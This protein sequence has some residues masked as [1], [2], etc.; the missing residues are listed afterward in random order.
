M[1]SQKRQGHITTPCPTA[2][3]RHDP[4][5]FA[6]CSRVLLSVCVSVGKFEDQTFFFAGLLVKRPSA[7]GPCDVKPN[8]RNS[9]ANSRHEQ[10]N[11][12]S[13]INVS[14]P[15]T[16]YVRHNQCSSGFFSYVQKKSR[17][18]PSMKVSGAVVAVYRS[19]W[20]HYYLVK[21]NVVLSNTIWAEI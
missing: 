14:T 10:R 5:M 17:V 3:E 19:I 4:R 20:D 18:F 12:C 6:L 13:I 1:L 21:H 16:I 9:S 15:S 8:E 11:F 7:G 2:L